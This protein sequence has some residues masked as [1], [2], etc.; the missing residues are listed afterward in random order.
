MQDE[1]FAFF[2]CNRIDRWR[3]DALSVLRSLVRQLSTRANDSDYIHPRLQQLYYST[4]SD[5]S[6]LNILTKIVDISTNP[7]KIFISSRPDIDI[8]D[9]LASRPSVEIQAKNNGDDIAKFSNK[10]IQKHPRW[11]T[12]IRERLG[13]LPV[14][15]KAAYD[16]IYCKVQCLHPDEKRLIDNAFKWVLCSFMPLTTA[17]L[18]PAISQDVE[19]DD[20]VSVDGGVDE[21]FLL[22]R[23]HN[24]LVLDSQ[25]HVWR[26][27]HLSVAEYFES[28]HWNSQQIH[29]SIAKVCLI[30]L[31]KTHERE[32]PLSE[33]EVEMRDSSDEQ[34][35]PSLPDYAPKYITRFK[36]DRSQ[37]KMKSPGTGCYRWTGSE[38]IEDWEI[39]PAKSERDFTHPLQ[40]YIR[41]HWMIHVKIQE[42]EKAT[43]DNRLVALL[44]AFLGSP[45]YSSWSYRG[46]YMD[47]ARASGGAFEAPNAPF[48]FPVP[49]CYAKR[50]FFD[51]DLKPRTHASLAMALFGFYFTLLDWWDDPTI[52]NRM[53]DNGEPLLAIAARTGHMNICKHIIRAGVPVD[54]IFG[55][56]YGT[57]L[58]AAAATG[59][60]DIMKELVAAG[61]DV[62]LTMK[63]AYGSALAA[64]A[65][66]NRSNAV[67]LLLDM[68]AD[69]NMLLTK[70][71]Y[72]NALSAA[73]YMG[74]GAMA[75]ML[76]ARGANAASAVQSAM[77][78]PD[79]ICR[80]DMSLLLGETEATN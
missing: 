1:A 34:D 32:I 77:E 78:I 30:W 65:Y 27:S 71:S 5:A 21:S 62:N 54:Q 49:F 11:S 69:V 12:A 80:K 75:K 28:C 18:L 59:Q 20:L 61:A 24:L 57:A 44:K 48:H 9:R 64:A 56:H 29:R 74:H 73:I 70:G 53:N 51:F 16:E 58:A 63:G 55:G 19:G 8:R 7:V 33:I 50:A 45:F 41:H 35:L 46:W 10:E 43:P 17:A 38:I 4:R 66:W 15:L 22:E 52:Y 26:F 40:F 68:G 14:D 42:D 37:L 79:A 36:I 67:S 47:M 31:L 23:S 6:D 72:K 3:R 39:L 60:L 13:A 25:R 2:Y 76:I